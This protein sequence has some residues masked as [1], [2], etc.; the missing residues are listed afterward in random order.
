MITLIV[1]IWII[2][3]IVALTLASA[4]ITNYRREA[5]AEAEAKS[6]DQFRDQLAKSTNVDRSI[7]QF[8]D[9]NP[10]AAADVIDPHQLDLDLSIH[11]A[12]P[13][14]R[15]IAQARLVESTTKYQVGEH[16]RVI[17]CQ[18]GHQLEIG[19]VVE[20]LGV[21]YDKQAM[22]VMYICFPLGD[23]S[24]VWFLGDDEVEPAHPSIPMSQ[25]PVIPTM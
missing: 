14:T 8:P 17:A 24:D 7:S 6:W 12:Y 11:G 15:K 4:L 21:D 16:L 23:P 22:D 2:E 9:L 19:D 10:K 20:V 1:I 18:W 13:E 5:K 25:V 3:L